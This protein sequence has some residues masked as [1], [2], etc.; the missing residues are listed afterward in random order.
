MYEA[1]FAVMK[2]SLLNIS[3]NEAEKNGS[4]DTEIVSQEYCFV[5]DPQTFMI[6]Q[7]LFTTQLKS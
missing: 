1:N 2:Y 3:Y 6:G 7:A 5:F 4:V